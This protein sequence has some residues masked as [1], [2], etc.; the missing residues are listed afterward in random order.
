[1]GVFKWLY[2]LP[3]RIVSSTERA[4]VA[5]SVVQSETLGQTVMDPGSMSSAIAE[6]QGG[7]SEAGSA[8]SDR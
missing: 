8:D 1:M 3:G 4:V 6:L 5:S 2:R 7:Q